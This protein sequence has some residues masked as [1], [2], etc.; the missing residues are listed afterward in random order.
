MS[1]NQGMGQQVTIEFKLDLYGDFILLSEKA[2]VCLNPS[3]PPPLDTVSVL[4]QVN[5][6]FED[7]LDYYK[8]RRTLYR[9]S[10]PSRIIRTADAG[11]M[12]AQLP[13]GQYRLEVK[14]FIPDVYLKGTRSTVT[15][16][17][18]A[19][20]VYR[21]TSVKREYKVEFVLESGRVTT[22]QQSKD[23]VKVD[24]PKPTEKKSD[25]N[26]APLIG[27]IVGGFSIVLFL[28]SCFYIRSRLKRPRRSIGQ[29][30]E[31]QGAVPM[32][33]AYDMNV[34]L[35]PPPAYY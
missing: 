27:G 20:N 6:M 35:S 11:P 22:I 2:P 32:T 19:V 9:V 17:I 15:V 33:T 13:D 31:H 24:L 34:P 7:G 29:G 1:W 26:H 10:S 30:I 23:G 5:V 16:S 18:D 14:P 28:G 4:F 12:P 21:I 8:K 3:S 25:N